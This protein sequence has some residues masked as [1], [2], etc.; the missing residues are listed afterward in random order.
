MAQKIILETKNLVKDFGGLRAVREVSFALRHGE[1]RS[2]IGPNGAGKTTFFNLLS[3]RLQ[4]SAG[5][6]FYQG[7]NIAGLP[8]HKICRLGVAK[9]HQ[10]TS[11]FPGLTVLENVRLSAQMRVTRNN[12]WG[13]SQSLKQVNERALEILNEMGMLAKKDIIA[14]NLPYGDQR[15]LDIA[16]TM[17]TEPQIL[18]LDEPTAGMTPA[19]TQEMVT[20]VQR[21]AK[22]LTIAL[23]EHDMGVVMHI[24]HY[25]TVLHN[26]A[27]L[28]EGAP[29]EI[30][31][32]QEVQRVYLGGH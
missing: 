21:L 10:I 8:Q 28:A 3:G 32:N 7:R 13:R 6:I 25:I 30:H 20:L 2:I 16:I 31:C 29:E 26:G 19:E 1:I 23:I 17:A 14:G 9:S 4:P 12:F 5:S 24:S 15:Y 27:I 11:I 22:T 18:L